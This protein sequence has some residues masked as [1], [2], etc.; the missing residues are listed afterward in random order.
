MSKDPN[1]PSGYEVGYGK[2]PKANQFPP[3]R[4]GNV[5][6]RPRKRQGDLPDLG[7]VLDEPVA[8]RAGGKRKLMHPK[9]VAIRAL[10]KKGLAGDRRAIIRVLDQMATCGLLTSAASQEALPGVVVLPAERMPWAMAMIM[11]ERFGI[12]ASYSEAQLRAGSAAYCR[13]RSVVEA[14]I[15]AATGYPDLYEGDAS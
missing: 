8:V 4:S 13:T 7:K 1:Q 2:P 3:G 14:R 15:D 12:K 10:V 5:R 9:E 11:A 6:G